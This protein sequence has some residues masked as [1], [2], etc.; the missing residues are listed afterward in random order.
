MCQKLTELLSLK[1]PSVYVCCFMLARAS[2]K[3][4]FNRVQKTA[5]I[6]FVSRKI[7]QQGHSLAEESL[8]KQHYVLCYILININ[9][10]HRNVPQCVTMGRSSVVALR[11]GTCCTVRA[12]DPGRADAFIQS[13]HPTQP[14]VQWIPEFFPWVGWS[15]RE[16]R[17]SPSSNSEVTNE[18]SCTSAPLPLCRHV[19]TKSDVH[20]TV[21]RDKSL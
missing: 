6:I 16:V 9:M 19:V 3:I 2:A 13:L 4:F 8:Y 5:K 14:T 11:L 1:G 7:H 21:H 20:V 15:G 17:H 18:W 12:Q 10:Q